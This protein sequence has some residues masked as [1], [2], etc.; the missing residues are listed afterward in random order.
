MHMVAARLGFE[1]AMVGT[2]WVTPTLTAWTGLENTALTF[3]S[4][5]FWQG[6]LLG[7]AVSG[8]RAISSA[9]YCMLIRTCINSSY[10]QCKSVKYSCIYAAYMNR[11]GVPGTTLARTASLTKVLH[12]S[13][14]SVVTQLKHR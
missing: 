6:R 13:A 3:Y 11:G 14:S 10:G 1:R 5:V 9:D 4:V 8:C 7:L 12:C 2:G